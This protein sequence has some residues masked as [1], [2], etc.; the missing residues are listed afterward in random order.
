MLENTEEGKHGQELG[1]DQPYWTL[2]ATVKAD[3]SFSS[4]KIKLDPYLL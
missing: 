2:K 3:L 4:Q 1:E